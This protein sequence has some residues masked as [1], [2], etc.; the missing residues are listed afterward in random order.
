MVRTMGGG[1][2]YA[3]GLF[4]GLLSGMSEEESVRM[5]GRTT[6]ASLDQVKALAKT[7]SARIRR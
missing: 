1:D 6:T 2:R 4:Y 3:S 5:V 7:G